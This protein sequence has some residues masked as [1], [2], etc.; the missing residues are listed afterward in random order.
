MSFGSFSLFGFYQQP[1]TGTFKTNLSSEEKDLIVFGGNGRDGTIADFN[2]YFPYAEQEG[3]I[4][5]EIVLGAGGAYKILLHSDDD[6]LGARYA[7]LNLALSGD[8]YGDRNSSITYCTFSGEFFPKDKDAY[9][10][11]I[12]ISG[13]TTGSPFDYG[14]TLI[15]IS[16]DISSG[17]IDVSRF[18]LMLSGAIIGKTHSYN[19][20]IPFSGN[21]TGDMIELPRINLIIS[22]NFIPVYSDVSILSYDFD[23][24]SGAFNSAQHHIYVQEEDSATLGYSISSYLSSSR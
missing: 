17:N 15:G 24:Y 1:N 23:S 2:W 8:V 18:D 6:F 11:S 5:Y 22:G 4:P 14:Q 12:G 19:L 9:N 21:F 3:L 7:K 16:G 20:N 10:T 13:S